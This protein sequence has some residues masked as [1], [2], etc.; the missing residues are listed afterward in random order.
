MLTG[1]DTLGV[2][3]FC[4]VRWIGIISVF[5]NS[6]STPKGPFG[7]AQPGIYAMCPFTYMLKLAYSAQYGVSYFVNQTPLS[8]SGKSLWNDCQDGWH[9]IWEVWHMTKKCDTWIHPGKF[10]G[11]NIPKI[12]DHLN[13]F[14]FYR[15]PCSLVVQSIARMSISHWT[16]RFLHWK[17]V[18]LLYSLA[19]LLLPTAADGPLRTHL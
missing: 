18:W 14:E 12:V 7:L 1:Q 8:S 9:W 19:S 17:C 5:L 2:R 16:M 6:T 4:L 15:R 13:C 3:M 10:T 11:D